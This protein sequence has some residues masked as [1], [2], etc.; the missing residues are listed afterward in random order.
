MPQ[1]ADNSALSDRHYITLI[2]R[3]TL[4]R[5]GDLVQGD[6]VDTTNQ[7]P[8]HFIGATGLHKVVEAWLRKQHSEDRQKPHDRAE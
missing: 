6:L 1:A 5:A 7:L 2:L 4:D 8:K 3:L